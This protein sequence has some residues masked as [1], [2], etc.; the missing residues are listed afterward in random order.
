MAS[1]KTKPQGFGPQAAFTE[2]YDENAGAAFDDI[3]NDPNWDL[4]HA[5]RSVPIAV[6]G[7]KITGSVRVFAPNDQEVL[8]A[9]ILDEWKQG[10]MDVLGRRR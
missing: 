10:V 6:F 8:V 1:R 7:N 9:K 3:Q 4:V 5:D 2:A